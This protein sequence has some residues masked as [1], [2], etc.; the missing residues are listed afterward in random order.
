MLIKKT[1][2]YTIAQC[3]KRIE[4]IKETTMFFLFKFLRSFK[5]LD[6]VLAYFSLIYFTFTLFVSQIIPQNWI[7]NYKICFV[8]FFYFYLVVYLLLII[9]IT[10]IINYNYINC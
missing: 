6:N 2:C 1:V 4:Q 7:T 9:I 8:L 3:L 10:I 5:M